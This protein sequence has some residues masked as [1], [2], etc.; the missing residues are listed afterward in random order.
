MDIIWYHPTQDGDVWLRGM[1]RRLPQA[2]VRRWQPGDDAPADYA[3]LWQ[4]PREMLAHRAG[5]RGVFV[6]GAGVDDILARLA[7]YP[8]M[9]PPSVPLVRL[10]DSGMARQMQEYA[11]CCVL[12]WFR[13]FDDYARQQQ[14]AQW[15]PLPPI[16][17]ET[18][19]VGVLGAGVLGRSV[20][21][22]LRPWG[23]PLRVWSRTPKRIDG[24]ESF[25]GRESL[26][27]FL[28]GAQVAINLLPTT[29]ETLN[30]FDA[31][32]LS[33]LPQ[34]ACFLNMAR[35]AQVVE[36]DL[37]AA[38]ESGRLRAAAL[39][40]FQQ[41]PLPQEH[42]LWR[43]PRVTV[44]PHIAALTLTDEAMDAITRAIGAIEAGERPSGC[45]DRQRGY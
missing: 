31:R 26:D 27:D 32:T 18:F 6:M 29:P 42:P 5:L 2:R 28:R 34:H 11:L 8:E 17:R 13:R 40:V 38:L 25:A 14:Q 30:L 4:P 41:E 12:G 35:G 7:R 21:E 19:S 20:V 45:V 44:T 23:F 16:P 22:A 39:D 15:Q 36:T 43:H 1:Q 37:L 3:I 24:V 9:L 10:E 33:Q